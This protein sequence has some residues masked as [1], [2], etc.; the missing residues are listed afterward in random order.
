[1]KAKIFEKE[2]L[3]ISKWQLAGK[4]KNRACDPSADRTAEMRKRAEN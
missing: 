2:Q 4:P 1:V 3:A